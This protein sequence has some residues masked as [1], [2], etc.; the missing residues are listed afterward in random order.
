MQVQVDRR[1]KEHEERV[2][3]GL[4]TF[5]RSQYVIFDYE[6]KYIGFGGPNVMKP[7]PDPKPSPDQPPKGMSGLV[8]FFIIF[9]LLLVLAIG[10]VFGV[11]KYRQRKL[12]EG[13][14]NM[15]AEGGTQQQRL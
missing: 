1:I 6:R 14:L 9:G 5:A 11:K 15:D 10:G 8:I 7:K 3:I 12:E 4:A 13:L 2:E